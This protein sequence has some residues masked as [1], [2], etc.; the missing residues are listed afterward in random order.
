MKYNADITLKFKN[1]STGARV[2]GPFDSI[3]AARDYAYRFV[4]ESILSGK[5]NDDYC[6][7]NH[8]I[9]FSSSKLVGE[10]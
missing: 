2:L 5:D 7:V 8:K 9:I 3:E 1:G 4:S 10:V 6:V